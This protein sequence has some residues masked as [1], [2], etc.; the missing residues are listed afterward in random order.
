MLFRGIKQHDENDCAAACLASICMYYRKKIPLTMI[1]SYMKNTTQGSNAYGISQAAEKLGLETSI[2]SGNLEELEEEINISNINLPCIAHTISDSGMPH[3]LVILSI[4]KNKIHLF[5]PALGTV[6]EDK[7]HFLKKWTGVIITCD[8]KEKFYKLTSAKQSTSMLIAI[9]GNLKKYIFITIFFSLIISVISLISSLVYKE[10]IDHYVLMGRDDHSHGNVALTMN[11]II[12]TVIIFYVLQ[13]ILGLARGVVL[14][15]ITEVA[16]YKLYEAFIE[17]LLKLKRDFFYSRDS[18]EILSRYQKINET[19][20][21]FSRVFFTI[22]LESLSLL[23]SGYVL[24]NIDLSLFYIVLCMSVIYIVISIL[25]IPVLNNVKRKQIQLNSNAITILNEVIKSIEIVKTNM[26]EKI[27]NRRYLDQAKDISKYNR[28]E[29]LFRNI[30]SVLIVFIESIGLILIL[31][32]GARLVTENKITLGDLIAFE[33][34]V[35]FF[36]LPLKSLVESQHDIQNVYVN[37]EKLSDILEAESEE[38]LSSHNDKISVDTENTNIVS[39]KNVKF[40]YDYS[41]NAIDVLNFDIKKGDK[42][43][44]M[45]S[46]GSGKT[47]LLKI[48][49]TLQEPDDGEVLFKGINMYENVIVS[50]KSISYVPQTSYIFSGTIKENI[51]FEENG[52]ERELNSFELKLGIFKYLN[53]FN[54]GLDTVVV[55][56]GSNLSGG[57]RQIIGLCRAI[58]QNKDILLLD[59]ATSN[60]EEDIETD[61][62]EN[63]QKFGKDKTIVAIIHNSKLMKYFD[64]TIT[65]KN[66]TIE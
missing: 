39:L 11:T 34:L 63:I 66:G 35:P 13:A 2:L 52:S 59:E 10:I 50:R 31:F 53:N 47:T 62:F 49:A 19:Q 45:G 41:T 42:I 61:F 21:V 15:R 32:L 65:I 54:F 46:N 30:S 33:T 1:R 7:K 17:K 6:K 51:I 28:K 9:F 8:P 22:I 48:L 37:M 26:I 20:I 27:F 36:I 25:F 60:M 3:F 58:M 18:G 38:K 24:I 55:E 23:V 56:N 12:I 57:Q 40:S 64:K 43:C 44:I 29:V 5:D 16:G 14:S 4:K